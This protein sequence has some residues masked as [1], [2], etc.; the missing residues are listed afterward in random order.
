MNDNNLPLT[1]IYYIEKF[2]LGYQLEGVH[3][4]ESSLYLSRFYYNGLPEDNDNT[5]IQYI[6]LCMI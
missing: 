6:K 1:N 4:K 5:K 3:N 2:H